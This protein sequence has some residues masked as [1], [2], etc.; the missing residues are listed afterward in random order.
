MSTCGVFVFVIEILSEVFE[1]I[2]WII[3]NII[4]FVFDDIKSI[5]I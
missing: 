1:F 3:I 5:W 2:F 4:F